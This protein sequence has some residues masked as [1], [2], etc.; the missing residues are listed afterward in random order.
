MSG[1]E[2]QRLL[3]IASAIF[4]M[5]ALVLI[6]GPELFDAN[7]GRSAGQAREIEYRVTPTARDV[8]AEALPLPKADTWAP[9]GDKGKARVRDE[10]YARRAY[11]GAPPVIPHP[12]EFSRGAESARLCA[13]CHVKGGFVPKLNAYAPVTPHPGFTNCVQCHV[14]QRSEVL[15]RENDWASVK[16]PEVLQAALPLG[17]PPI[18]HALEMRENCL[19]CHFGPSSREDIRSPHPERGNCRQCHVPRLTDEVFER[20]EKPE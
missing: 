9:A 7:G 20:R 15:F 1:E 14:P 8:A 4:L 11:P 10:Y 18:P 17:P 16:K 12:V 3:A 19:A 5:T 2:T 6:F 13:A